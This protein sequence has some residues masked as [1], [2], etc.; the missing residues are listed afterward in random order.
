MRTGMFLLV[1]CAGTLALGQSGMAF[2][3]AGPT[4]M[5]RI[6]VA[7]PIE[8]LAHADEAVAEIGLLLREARD[9][10]GNLP[11][12]PVAVRQCY[13]DAAN[14]IAD[15][16]TTAEAASDALRAA[17]MAD[18]SDRAHLAFGRLA[19]ALEAARREEKRDCSLTPAP[20]PSQHAS[21]KAQP[22][23]PPTSG[24]GAGRNLLPHT[25]EFRLRTLR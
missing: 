15:E 6:L 18:Q 14:H 23:A 16:L 20:S 19:Q 22:A 17:W 21:P 11:G 12:R 8:Q 2:G 1:L 7:T 5:D 3:Q 4:L 10:A 25:Q 13:I 24:G 9:R